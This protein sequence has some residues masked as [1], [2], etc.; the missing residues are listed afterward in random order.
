[1]SEITWNRDAAA[2]LLRRAGFGPTP[3]EID[4]LAALS[5]EAAV[6][7]LVD[8]ESTDNSA[9]E[10][11]IA[12]TPFGANL[13]GL[14]QRFLTRMAYTARPLEE[15]MTYFWNLHWTS[16]WDKVRGIRNDHGAT[17][18][19]V[20]LNQN[21][22]ERSLVLAS[23]DDIALALTQDAA[24][25]FW[26]DNWQ[27]VKAKPNENYARE[28]MELFTIGIGNYTQ[29]D[30][31]EVARSLTGWTLDQTRTGFFFNASRHDDGM[32]TVLGHTGNFDGGDA[33][34]IILNQRNASGELLCGRFLGAKLFSFF[35]Y[36]DPPE[37]VVSEL[38][39]VFDANNRSVRELLRHLFNMPEF[40]AGHARYQWVRSPSEF[41]VA[42]ARLTGATT[43]F[44][45][46][47]NLL[48]NMGQVL[49][50]PSDAKGWSWGTSWI[51]TGALFA[52]GSFAN[53]LAS[54][55]GSHGTFFDPSALLA[56]ANLSNADD[57]VAF[58]ADRFGIVGATPDTTASWKSYLN[59]NDD[60][61]RGT[62][63][64][65]AVGVDKKIRGLV[66]VMLTS[67]DFQLA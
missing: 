26:L 30:V 21:N 51:T 38:A 52:R 59:A 48:G 63:A 3:G 36:P 18:A 15:K 10:A 9:L 28:L 27:N 34:N 23:F 29:T 65:N 1:M 61:S 49:F 17:G 31:T 60:G 35:A 12:A 64:D 67:P 53:T 13:F 4:E 37:S 20:L 58:L 7:R 39:A 32:K 44:Q 25:L 43:D 55:R 56:G 47:I 6:D 57:A 41:L 19:A 16:G 33:I 42:A 66:H 45:A 46:G 22:T 54:N 62:W 14:T 50:D 8:Y 40:Y 2:H 24:M 5:R 11:R